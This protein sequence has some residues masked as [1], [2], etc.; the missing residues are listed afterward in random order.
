M[1]TV[2]LL[3]RKNT[4]IKVELKLFCKEKIVCARCNFVF[5]LS[6]NN[7]IIYRLRSCLCNFLTLTAETKIIRWSL[8]SATKQV[9]PDLRGLFANSWDMLND[10]KSV[11]S[12]FLSCRFWW[13]WVFRAVKHFTG[14]FRC[15]H[16][17]CHCFHYSVLGSEGWF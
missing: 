13:R 7:K 16:K 8:G 1:S 14:Y 10:F 4:P 6:I 15:Q 11:V 9:A 12:F 17:K 5:W 3:Q 2:C